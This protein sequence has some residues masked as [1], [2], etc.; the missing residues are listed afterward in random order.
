M[1]KLI[2]IIV[3]ALLITLSGCSEGSDNQPD[4]DA[5]SSNVTIWEDS[6]GEKYIILAVEVSN[7]INKPLY[8]KESDFDIVDEEGELIDTMKSVSAYPS[9][10]DPDK[11]AVY[12]DAKISDKISDTNIRLKA[13]PHIESEK[14][15]VKQANLSIKGVTVGGSKY[16]FG[17][18]QNN[19]SQMEYN[20]VHIAIISRKENDEVV[21]VMTTT[22]NSIKPRE[23]VEFIVKDCLTQRDLGPDIVTNYQ[24]FVYITP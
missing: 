3:L 17:I 4:F 22:I 18:V 7:S 9:V 8:F 14:S 2:I 10:V 1:K 11:T 16:A 24:N 12:Y 5:V 6:T 23:Q 13:V 15:R 21:S 19:S 20:N